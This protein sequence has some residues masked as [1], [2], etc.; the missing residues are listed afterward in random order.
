MQFYQNIDEVQTAYLATATADKQ[1]CPRQ[2]VVLN[3]KIIASSVSERPFKHAANCPIEV[4]AKVMNKYIHNGKVDDE[5]PI[6][7]TSDTEGF[8]DNRK[9]IFSF[10]TPSLGEN[11]LKPI[12]ITSEGLMSR[13]S[14]CVFPAN[15]NF[16]VKSEAI[17]VDMYR[18][19]I[20]GQLYEE[21]N[22]P[23]Q[24][25]DRCLEK[26]SQQ[27]K[28]ERN[29]R[30]S[31]T[32]KYA[33]LSDITVQSAEGAKRAQLT[34][35]EKSEIIAYRQQLRDLP[36]VQGFPFVDFPAIPECIKYEAEK[37]IQNRENMERMH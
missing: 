7:V 2:A 17:S 24:S 37:M 32:D 12:S 29:A 23:E 8:L 9:K 14:V 19:V 1:S 36:E 27:I 21:A 11:S 3:N 4:T 28:S 6:L 5:A 25:K 18:S 15:H 33:E 34:S 26:Y 13:Y 16:A 10:V 30:I 22:L 31:D 35:D 20:D